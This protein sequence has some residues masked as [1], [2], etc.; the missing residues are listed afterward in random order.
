M[1]R[2]GFLW[3]LVAG[4]AAGKKRGYADYAGGVERFRIY[5]DGKVGIGSIAPP[6]ELRFVPSGNVGIGISNPS[7]A[8]E[9]HPKF[10]ADNGKWID[11][12]K[13]S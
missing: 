10:L 9:I 12:P 6:S 11:A 4:F 1:K 13:S 5:S 2:R 7:T 3:S 8:L